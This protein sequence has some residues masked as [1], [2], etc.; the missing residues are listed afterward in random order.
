VFIDRQLAGAYGRSDGLYMKPP[1]M[2][3]AAT[4]GYQLPDTP[5]ARYRAGSLGSARIHPKADMTRTWRQVH[6][7][8]GR[9]VQ[10]GLPRTT[11]SI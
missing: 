10:D 4:Q 2:P 3:G 6:V 5:A 7:W 8:P 9:A 1:F 11:N